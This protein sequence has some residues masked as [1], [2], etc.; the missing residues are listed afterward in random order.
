MD[1]F[2]RSAMITADLPEFLSAFSGVDFSGV[3]IAQ[4]VH[5][6]V[7]NPVELASTSAID[8]EC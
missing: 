3:D 5:C 1:L 6:K 4:R 2:S 7:M 8:A